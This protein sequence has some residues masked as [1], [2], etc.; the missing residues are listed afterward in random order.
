MATTER[1]TTKRLLV[2]R[3]LTRAVADMLREQA[4][5]HVQTLAPL[6]R[7]RLA[8]GEPSDLGSREAFQS[9]DKNFRELQALFEPLAGSDPFNLRKDLKPPLEIVSWEV[10]LSPLEYRHEA[11]TDEGTKVINIISPLK[12]VMSFAGM[13][14]GKMSLVS[15]NPRRFKELLADRSRNTEELKQFMLHYLAMNLAITRSPG[16][17]KIFETLHFP[18]RTETVAELGELPVPCITSSISTLVP[19]DDV[20]VEH[21]EIAG[22][23]S[24]EEVVSIDDINNLRDPLREKLLELVK[25]HGAEPKGS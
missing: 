10:E 12:W 25:A 18:L 17:A 1:F 15:Y 3:K 14:A 19:P 5:Q 16:L 7:P 20:L 2:L 22:T 11:T 24:F 4:K 21:T 23:D 13:S 6:M 9:V 8:L